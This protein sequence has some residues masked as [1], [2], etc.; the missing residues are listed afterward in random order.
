MRP[1]TALFACFAATILSAASVNEAGAST[2]KDPGSTPIQGVIAWPLDQITTSNTVTQAPTAPQPA[3]APGVSG[4]SGVPKITSKITAGLV[5]GYS[6]PNFSQSVPD[7]PPPPTPTL[8]TRN[9]CYVTGG[10]VMW[11]GW[12]NVAGGTCAGGGAGGW[13]TTSPSY[14]CPGT[15]TCSGAGYNGTYYWNSSTNQYV[16][17][18]TPPPSCVGPNLTGT[19]YWNTSSRT[20]DCNVSPPPPPPAMWLVCT[21]VGGA[22]GSPPWPRRCAQIT[23]AQAMCALNT[24]IQK[25][26]TCGRRVCYSDAP[27]YARYYLPNSIAAQPEGVRNDGVSECGF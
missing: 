25:R 17:N 7:C 4:L 9:G 14:V 21:W 6:S 18:Y 23:K 8:P 5:T 22:H 1:T 11:S 2:F 27:A 20:W 3:G 26:Y 13:V 16:C 15:P 19:Y 24:K 12:D 10:S